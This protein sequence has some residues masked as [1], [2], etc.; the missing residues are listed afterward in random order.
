MAF[1]QQF[2]VKASEIWLDN[3]QLIYGFTATG[4]VTIFFY[5]YW[6]KKPSDARKKPFFQLKI[7]VRRSAKNWVEKVRVSVENCAALDLRGWWPGRWILASGRYFT[8]ISIAENRGVLILGAD[9]SKSCLAR[10]NLTFWNFL[11][12]FPRHQVVAACSNLRQCD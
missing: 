12:Q 2:L 5:F 9:T 3:K 11:G 10:A 7:F 8:G 6:T 4:W 1:W